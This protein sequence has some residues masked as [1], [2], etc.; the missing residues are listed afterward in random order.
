M[1]SNIFSLLFFFLYIYTVTNLSQTNF[2]EAYEMLG[3]LKYNSNKKI[4]MVSHY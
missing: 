3:R 4:M 1:S 2:R